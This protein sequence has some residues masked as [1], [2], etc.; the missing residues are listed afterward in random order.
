MRKRFKQLY[1]ESR[2]AVLLDSRVA[3]IVLTFA[4]LISMG[5]TGK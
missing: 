1:P 5:L 3:L 4:L 2:L